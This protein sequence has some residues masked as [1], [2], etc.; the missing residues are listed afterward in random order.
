MLKPVFERMS[1]DKGDPH[2]DY[3]YDT[4]KTDGDGR[5]LKPPRW[6][7]FGKRARK[8]STSQPYAYEEPQHSHE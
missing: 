7:S 4:H 5:P 3:S 8:P 2:A 1:E 6:L